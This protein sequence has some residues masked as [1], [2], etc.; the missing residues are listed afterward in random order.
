M[1][2][3]NIDR[4]L[5]IHVKQNC[6]KPSIFQLYSV[7]SVGPNQRLSM[8]GK[9]EMPISAAWERLGQEVTSPS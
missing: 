2:V 3:N 1:R 4:N 8:V 5:V 9:Y 7:L 6:E